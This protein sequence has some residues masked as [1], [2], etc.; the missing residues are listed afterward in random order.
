[1]SDTARAVLSVTG[2]DREKF[3]QDLVTNTIP[4]INTGLVYAALLTPQG[5][6][7]F[8]FFLLR[9]EQALF[10]DVAADRAQQLIRRLTM[11]RL[12]AAVSVA[13][14]D[15]A[16][17]RGPGEPP[18]G[19]YAD[20]RHPALGWRGYDGQPDEAVDWDAIRVKH[21]IPETGIELIAGQSYI[22]ECGFDRLNGVDFRKGCYVGQEVTARMRHKTTPNKGLVTVDVTGT[23]P[24]GTMITAEGKEAGF[25]FT[26]SGGRA[27]A[28]LR[29][30]R[31]RGEMLAGATRVTFTLPD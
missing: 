30:H 29:F 20:P 10:I 23:A 22:L 19:A 24:V 9:R 17:S 4:G 2:A 27:I 21:C 1:M 16:V 14:T 15:R 18:D 13:G 3:L 12:R 5:K 6:F 8:D 11:Y 25:L 26:Q 31:A 28:Y 7:L